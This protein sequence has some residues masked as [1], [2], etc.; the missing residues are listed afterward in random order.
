MHIVIGGIFPNVLHDVRLPS[1]VWRVVL[2][3]SLQLWKGRFLF[4]A[5]RR[6]KG[7]YRLLFCQSSREH[8]F[9]YNI[10]FRI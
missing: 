6:L 5:E 2:H 7:R 9:N 3:A 10:H 8:S 4:T 1:G